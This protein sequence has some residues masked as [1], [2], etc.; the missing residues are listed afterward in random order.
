M[1]YKPGIVD[2]ASF[3]AVEAICRTFFLLRER[4]LDSQRSTSC[5][6]DR[7]DMDIAN[8]SLNSCNVDNTTI[9]TP[10]TGTG[11]QILGY[12]QHRFA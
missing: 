3:S 1:I 12:S 11:F 2:F 7:R 5:S 10:N 4:Q 8:R 6:G 9:L